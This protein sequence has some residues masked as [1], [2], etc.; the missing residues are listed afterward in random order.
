MTV[1]MADLQG[2]VRQRVTLADLLPL[3]FGPTNLQDD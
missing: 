3:G 2:A 1:I